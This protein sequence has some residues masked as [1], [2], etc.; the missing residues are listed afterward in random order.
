VDDSGAVAVSYLGRYESLEADYAE[1]VRRLAI[2]TLP[3]DHFNQSYHPAWP[4]L[5]TPETF[6]VVG[7]L[8]ERDAALFGYAQ[9][10]RAYGIG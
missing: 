10:A 6:A 8:V 3:L 2:D 5:Y 7:K 1:I 9:D 4:S